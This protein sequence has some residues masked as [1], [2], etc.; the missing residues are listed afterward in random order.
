[1]QIGMKTEKYCFS[2][3][4]AKDPLLLERNKVSE[5]LMSKCLKCECT[6]KPE[7]DELDGT[8]ERW[9]HHVPSRHLHSQPYQDLARQLKVKETRKETLAQTRG[10]RYP[11]Y[12]LEH[13]W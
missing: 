10:I 7:R 8:L 9:I 13:F 3:F 11:T 1:M 12:N 4:L 2:L 6:M 5:L